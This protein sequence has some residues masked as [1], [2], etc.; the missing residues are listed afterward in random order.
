MYIN[1]LTFA[2][3]FVY[4][5]HLFLLTNLYYVSRMLS[6]ETLCMYNYADIIVIM[7]RVFVT[8]CKYMIYYSYDFI[9]CKGSTITI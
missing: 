1:S 8:I 2:Y 4:F 7:W 5:Y 9:L 3:L 6:C